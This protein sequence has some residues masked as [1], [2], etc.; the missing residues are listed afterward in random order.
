MSSDNNSATGGANF[1]L[2]GSSDATLSACEAVQT[3]LNTNPTVGFL[4]DTAAANV[5][6]EGCIANSHNNSVAVSPIYGNGF[7]IGNNASPTSYV[8][9][10]DCKA[11]N[12]Q[13]W[14][15]YFDANCGKCQVVG[16]TFVTNG[17]AAK[18]RTPT[19]GSRLFS[20]AGIGTANVAIE[21]TQVSNVE[22]AHFQYL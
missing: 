8:N 20:A 9:V 14:G 6:L 13:N 7:L 10:N 2:V 19:A 11:H 1:V 22:A 12:N 4:I 3:T 18:F 15:L 21:L 16:G 5:S 17:T